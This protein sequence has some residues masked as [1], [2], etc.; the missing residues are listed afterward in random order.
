MS[1]E[2]TELDRTVVDEIGDPLM[3][4]LRNAADHGLEETAERLKLGKPEI[5]SVFLDAYQEGNNVIIEV[6]DD[7]AGVDID[8]I[9][10]KAIERGIISFDQGENMTEKDIIDL[11]FHAGFSTA[12][13][14]TDVSGR[15]VGL[16]VVKSKIEALS[17]EVEVKSVR[18]EGSVWTV[19][20]PL[21]LAIIQALMVTVGG[22][23]YAL[24][25]GSIQTI[26]DIKPDDIKLVQNKEVINLR[27]TV[28]P[29]LRMSDILEIESKKAPDEDMVVVIVKK[30]DKLAGLIV[31]ELMG[32]Q[33]IVIKSLGKYIS[34]CKFISGA[35][36]LGDGEVAL[37]LDANVLI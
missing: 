15:G 7:G 10:K 17:G 28:I 14:L 23:K 12:E 18:G 16:D 27:G 36:I 20:L 13:V 5:G 25:L 29:I 4:L 21:T 22:E 6:R 31:D 8:A 24:S 2:E 9:K 30:A 33:E 26:E 1:G 19:R 35:T 37:I 11:L 34:K 3:H 32:Q